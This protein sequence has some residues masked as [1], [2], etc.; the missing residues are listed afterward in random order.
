MYLRA[1][2]YVSGWNFR[3]QSEEL[4]RERN[5]FLRLVELFGMEE[6]VT[7]DSPSAYV[8]FTIGYWR[9][10]NQIHNWFVENVQGGEDECE[11]HDVSREQLTELREVCLRVLAG[12]K[13]VPGKVHAGTIYNAEHPKGLVQLEEGKVIEDDSA[14]HKLLPTQQ[15]FFFGG[16]EYD[17]WYYQ[18]VQE[19]VAIIDKALALLDQQGVYW[20]IVYQS[21]W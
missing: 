20:D 8:E 11:P 7:D 16:T 21:S 15:G 9:K 5:E 2:K 6:S 18:G 1:R 17:E 4:R 12:S 19:T 3:D 13:L 14:A 10:A